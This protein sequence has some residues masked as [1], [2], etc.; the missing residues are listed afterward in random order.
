[1]GTLKLAFP[2]LWNL[3]WS[4]QLHHEVRT[5]ETS[6]FT[7]QSTFMSFAGMTS[8]RALMLIICTPN[9]DD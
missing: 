4:D 2:R 1:M 8:D 7:G 3:S 9:S 5:V 6:L